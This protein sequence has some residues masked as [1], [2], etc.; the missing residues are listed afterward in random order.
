MRSW[1]MRLA[2]LA[3]LSIVT[4][5]SG[6][7]TGTPASTAPAKPISAADALTGD[8]A[9]QWA[10]LVAAAKVEGQIVFITGVTGPASDEP[11]Y[12]EFGKRFGLK[13]TSTGGSSDT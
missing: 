12:Q 5:C 4:A 10:D 1:T 13:V 11:L 7:G 6:G 3:V 2:L 9:K 8:L